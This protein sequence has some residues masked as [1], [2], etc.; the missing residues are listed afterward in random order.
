M[1]TRSTTL[2]KPTLTRV[3]H[4]V[5]APAPVQ[6]AQIAFAVMAASKTATW[7]E[8]ISTPRLADSVR[9]TAHQQEVIE[10]FRFVLPNLRR[11]GPVVTVEA[12]PECGRWGWSC[13]P[14]QKRCSWTPGCSGAPVK[15][16]TTAWKPPSP[17]DVL[18]DGE[19]VL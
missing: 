6:A 15:A 8:A 7:A 13:S 16:A 3:L 11:R 9:L 17:A 19:V 5:N 10:S 2:R 1:A 4:D 18:A 14:V 12:C